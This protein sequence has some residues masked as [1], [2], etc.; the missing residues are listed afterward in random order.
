VFR[1]EGRIAGRFSAKK[2]SVINPQWISRSGAPGSTQEKVS[3]RIAAIIFA[4]IFWFGVAE[5][6]ERAITVASTTSTEQS[7][8]FGYCPSSRKLRAST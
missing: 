4:A 3:M 2:Y 6:H 5:A 7:G 1:S 8:L